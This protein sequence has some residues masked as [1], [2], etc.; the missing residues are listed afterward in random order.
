M[1]WITF[2]LLVWCFLLLVSAAIFGS[3]C[4]TV[5]MHKAEATAMQA[6]AVAKAVCDFDATSETCEYM[7]RSLQRFYALAK[8]VERE[9]DKDALQALEEFGEEILDFG[10]YLLRQVT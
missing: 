7:V 2:W 9:G 1:K 4:A 10:R 6:K 3:G 5:N 8:V